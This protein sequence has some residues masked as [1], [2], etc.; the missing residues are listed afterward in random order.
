MNNI[1]TIHKCVIH[2]SV[3]R[4]NRTFLKRCVIHQTQTY[5]LKTIT[6]ILFK[7]HTILY[8]LFGNEETISVIKWRHRRV[9]R[10][11]TCRMICD[12]YE[13][14]NRKHSLSSVYIDMF[15]Y[16]DPAHA[17]SPLLEDINTRTRVISFYSHHECDMPHKSIWIPTSNTRLGQRC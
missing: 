6:Y 3:V 2:L 13:L 14:F 11:R 12:E 7:Y 8:L 5:E 9:D 15:S 16:E 17:K 4:L 10:E 1:F